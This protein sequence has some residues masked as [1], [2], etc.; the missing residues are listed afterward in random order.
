MV[1]PT[2]IILSDEFDSNEIS[3]GSIIWYINDQIDNP[4]WHPHVVIA[5]D[6]G[7]YYT[8]CG[9][10]QQA[11]IERK[12]NNLRLPDYSHFPALSPT[13]ANKLSKC[14]FFDCTDYYEIQECVL[15]DKYQEG[16]K[17]KIGGCITYSDY[18]Q[19]RN[20]LLSTSTMDIGDLLIHPE[21]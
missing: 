12:A 16:E 6:E 19:I 18:T 14:T 20:A 15:Q 7:T 13:P 2:T 10:S 5:I 21:D 9:T 4:E 1:P 8:V 11:T 17:V 3:V